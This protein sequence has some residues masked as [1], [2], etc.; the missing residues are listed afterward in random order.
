MLTEP[1]EG[2]KAGKRFL[3]G[4]IP[5][6]GAPIIFLSIMFVVGLAVPWYS[7]RASEAER[8]DQQTSERTNS[9]PRSAMKRGTRQRIRV[10]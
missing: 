6:R 3:W 8:G 1:L 9:L 4:E 7:T 2:V 10:A 5:S